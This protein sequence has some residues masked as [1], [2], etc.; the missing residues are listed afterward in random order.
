MELGA[1]NPESEESKV[2]CVERLLRSKLPGYILNV[3]KAWDTIL[4]A[5]PVRFL[6]TTLNY[7]IP[8]CC[9]RAVR[10]IQIENHFSIMMYKRY[11]SYKH[12]MR[13]GTPSS[14]YSDRIGYDN[15]RY[16]A[17][18]VLRLDRRPPPGLNIYIATSFTLSWLQTILSRQCEHGVTINSPTF[19]LNQQYIKPL[20]E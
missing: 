9:R 19:V 10:D 1:C 16:R 13:S 20:C 15:Y 12:I 5:R 2:K 6:V 11:V 7:I 14:F 8:G 4:R 18:R 17:D 3:V